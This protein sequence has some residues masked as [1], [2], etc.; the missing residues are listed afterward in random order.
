MNSQV[1]LNAVYMSTPRNNWGV[2]SV[3]VFSG[4]QAAAIWDRDPQAKPAARQ[5]AMKIVVLPFPLQEI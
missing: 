4:L 2:Q 1:V 5:F 3:T